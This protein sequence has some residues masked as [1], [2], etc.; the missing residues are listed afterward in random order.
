MT[1]KLQY[2]LQASGIV[3]PAFRIQIPCMAHII[4]LSWGAFMSS[5][6]VKGCPKS[7][8]SHEPNPQ[9]G[10]NESIDIRKHHRLQTEG[11]AR[12]NQ[13]SAMRPCLANIIGKARISRSFVILESDLHIAVNACCIDYIDTGLSKQLHLLSE[14]QSMNRITTYYGCENTVDLNTGVGWAILLIMRS[15]LRVA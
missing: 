15:H 6:G 7:W 5:L 8:E 2:T 13:V 10:E 3:W 4:E 12:I 14:I 1:S 9:F 11:N